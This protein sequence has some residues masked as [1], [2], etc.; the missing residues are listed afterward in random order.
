MVQVQNQTASQINN[1]DNLNGDFTMLWNNFTLNTEL[2]LS[3]K[4]IL[5]SIEKINKILSERWLQ[6]SKTLKKSEEISEILEK[7]SEDGLLSTYKNYVKEVKD[8]IKSTEDL[9]S[10][11]NKLIT[12]WSS[13][14]KFITL[15][16]L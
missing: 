2:E 13:I 10:I 1:I 11:A 6:N 8:A 14:G 16:N 5:E 15:L 12:A 9:T 4:E 7:K 3:K